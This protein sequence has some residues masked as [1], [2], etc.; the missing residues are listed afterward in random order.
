MGS[1]VKKVVKSV[2]KPIKKIVSSPV[3]QLGLAFFAPQFLPQLSGKGLFFKEALNRALVNA[4]ATKLSG[5]DVDL[6]SSLIAG[7]I[8]AA[9][10][11][12]PGISGMGNETLKRAAI[13]SL[14][15]VGTNLATGRDVNLQQA[16]LAGGLSAGVGA[17]QDRFAPMSMKQAL[18][19]D[20]LLRAE[21]G[22]GQTRT[23][24]SQDLNVSPGAEFAIDKTGDIDMGYDQLTRD[25]IKLPMDRLGTPLLGSVGDATQTASLAD[26][27]RSLMNRDIS[28]AAS[29]L[30]NYVTD[31]QNAPKVLLGAL[32]A[33]PLFFS[34]EQQEDETAAA[35]TQRRADVTGFLRQYGSNFYSGSELDDFISRTTS[36]LGY[37]SGGRVGYAEGSGGYESFKD[38]IEDTGDEELMN[39]YVD[40]LKGVQPEE[41]LFK[42]LRKKGYQSYA[43]GGRVGLANGSKDKSGIMMASDPSLDDSRNEIALELF[44]KYL[45]DL[46]EEE[47]EIL[48]DYNRGFMAKGGMPTGIMR[49]NAAG[50]KERD[51]RETGGFVPV[52]I[53]EKADDVPAMLS[54]NEFVMTADAVKGAGKGSIE[55]GAQKMYDTMK[56][57]EN[58]VA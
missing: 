54:K 5:G 45:K 49:T 10:P 34:P 20:D 11:N 7:G 42:L 39:I 57:L 9:V 23:E 37:A 8:G 12:I 35:F 38:F 1:K 24:I 19:E 30:A 50:I 21:Q 14:T 40:V 3:G 4:A 36:D 29:G 22:P 18:T 33:A 27:G 48:D 28:G 15:N 44:G 51:Y 43:S 16:A 13:G 56:E 41:A 47:L 52:G 58:R 2:V 53:K 25:G 6:K 32:T 31:K 46:T 26:I 17:L 55:K